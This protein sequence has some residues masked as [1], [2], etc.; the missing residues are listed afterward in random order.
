MLLKK[1]ALILYIYTCVVCPIMANTTDDKI[2][3]IQSYTPKT[4]WNNEVLQGINKGLSEKGINATIV[5]EYLDADY[6]SFAA[7]KDI[8]RKLCEKVKSDG[9]KLIMTNGDEAFHTLMNCGDSLPYKV[10]VVIMGVKYP[11]DSFSSLTNVSGYTSKA[12][13][14]PLLT[15]AQLL[16]PDRTEVICVVDSSFLANRGVME[17]K[18]AWQ[19]FSNE[20]PSYKLS[21]LN[22]QDVSMHRIISSIC[23]ERNAKNSVVMLPKWSPFLSFIGKN[24]KAPF[25]SI[26]NISLNNGV[27]CSFDSDP[28]LIGYNAGLDAGEILNG[29]SPTDVGIKDFKGDF[30]Y[31][32]K[33]LKFF[34]VDNHKIKK[35]AIINEPYWDTVRPLFI[36]VNVLIII[37][38][39]VI[40]VWLYRLKRRESSKRRQALN[41][42]LEQNYLVTQRDKFDNIFHSIRDAV[43][44]YDTNGEI[45]FTNKALQQMLNLPFDRST[46]T[47]EGMAAGSLFHVYNNGKEILINSL[48]DVVD[49]GESVTL[50]PESFIKEVVNGHYFPIS[51][52]LT[53]IRTKGTITG[54]AFS[55][56]NVTDEEMQKH[57]FNLAVEDSAIYPWQYNTHTNC[58]I[59]PPKLLL[60]F[61]FSEEV[62]IVSKSELI[63]LI[64]PADFE[65]IQRELSL[66]LEGKFKNSRMSF[67]I[68][69][70][71]NLYEWWEFRMTVYNGFTTE[72]PYSILGVCQSIQRYKAAEQELIEARD[73][74]LET[75]KLKSAFLANMSHE[76]RTPLNSIV[77]FSDLLNN[78]SLYSDKEIKQF[79]GIINTNCNLLLSLINDILDLSRIESGSMDFVFAS[80]NL[81]LILKNVYDS[82]QLNMPPGVKLILDLPQGEKTYAVTDSVRLQQ[83][84]NNL[85]NNAVKFTFEGAITI[86]LRKEENETVTI[87]VTDTGKGM[88]DES[89][90]HIFDRFYKVHNFTQGAGLGL[91]I[92]KTIIDR[93]NGSKIGR[94]SCRERG[95]SPV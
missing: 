50:P 81:S 71:N 7:E 28:F 42:L 85:V 70:S 61:G 53:P 18:K 95:S 23:E 32:Y 12:D 65:N 38:L 33:Q 46:R 77:G 94:A 64:L 55:F 10:P 40:I 79:I 37:L 75:D 66:V 54:V 9:V 25:F 21:I 1:I 30:I 45:F 4:L 6:W 92:C 24:S 60:S 67:R 13:F 57:F 82:Q 29:A 2:L 17:L 52:E 36:F 44:T 80:H 47:Y 84:V 78:S 69:N 11:N 63:N 76:I 39:I 41:R 8:I 51:G 27:F 89:V 48:K 5:T 49:K 62:S 74:A 43:I 14:Q 72:S 19:L 34:G 86:G 87:Y 20:N 22:T 58:F 31:D 88:S 3:F 35:G 59:F 90:K 91:S 26:Q 16:F 73:K 93:L 68:R 83:V 56:R 15:E